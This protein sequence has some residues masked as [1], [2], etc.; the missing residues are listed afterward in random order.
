MIQVLHSGTDHVVPI[1]VHRCGNNNARIHEASLQA[2]LSMAARPNYGCSYLGPF[3]LAPLPK[4]S[5][6]ASQMA[7]MNGRLSIVC[8][9]LTTYRS[10]SGLGIESL[11]SM[12]KDALDMPEEKVGITLHANPLFS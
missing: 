5:Q 4:K 3:A 7:Q 12:C 6:G 2:L 11:M 10:T 9:L 1:I 8:E